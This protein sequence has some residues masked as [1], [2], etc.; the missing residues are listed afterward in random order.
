MNITL[1]RN[2]ANTEKLERNMIHSNVI[3]DLKTTSLSFKRTGL[4]S[5]RSCRKKEKNC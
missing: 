3:R 2:G 1:V 5:L 4:T